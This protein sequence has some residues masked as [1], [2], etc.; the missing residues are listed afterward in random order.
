M[1]VDE[2]TVKHSLEDLLVP[3]IAFSTVRCLQITDCDLKISSLS[4]VFG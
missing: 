3:I 1:K 2:R 4:T